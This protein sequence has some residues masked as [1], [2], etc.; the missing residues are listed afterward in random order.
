MMW[1]QC[2]GGDRAEI[3]DSNYCSF[4]AYNVIIHRRVTGSIAF[5][6]S[7]HVAR[8][9]VTAYTYQELMHEGA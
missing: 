7:V 6:L 1:Q 4:S 3:T 9:T 2:S 5:R 8:S